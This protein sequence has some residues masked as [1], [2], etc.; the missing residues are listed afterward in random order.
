MHRCK[1]AQVETCVTGAP[2]P[3]RSE[4]LAPFGVLKQAPL[5]TGQ[6][7]MWSELGEPGQGDLWLSEL[8]GHDSPE[9]KQQFMRVLLCRA[10]LV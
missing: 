10:T 7:C 4:C 9:R 3:V 2:P 5:L 1:D 8:Q 6:H